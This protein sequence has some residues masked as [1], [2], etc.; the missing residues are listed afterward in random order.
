[1]GGAYDPNDLM[2]AMERGARMKELE[3]QDRKAQKTSKRQGRGGFGDGEGPTRGQRG[4]GRGK[5]AYPDE[6][7]SKSGL[8]GIYDK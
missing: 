2:A 5:A 3:D 8:A 6:Y 1:M 4:K 7:K